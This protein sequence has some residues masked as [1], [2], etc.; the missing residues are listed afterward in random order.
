MFL[1]SALQS[2]QE[3]SIYLLGEYFSIGP[4]GRANLSAF[5]FVKGYVAESQFADLEAARMDWN[6]F[7]N[8][9]SPIL[10]KNDFAEKIST[11]RNFMRGG[12]N[13]RHLTRIIQWEIMLLAV[14]FGPFAVAIDNPESR[15]VARFE[16]RSKPYLDS[17]DSA[18][19]SNGETAQAYYKYEKFLDVEL[20]LVFN[21]LLI[22]LDEDTRRDLVTSQ[23]KWLTHRDAEFIF[24]DNNWVAAKFGSSFKISRVAY[25]S[26]L[27]KNRVTELLYYL[28]NY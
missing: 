2:I 4:S 25:R 16:E 21:A 26:D 23:N 11:Q 6:T 17:I 1:I 5:K 18:S 9:I 14:W 12:I 3:T 20:N 7:R 8:K 22:E 24:I 15:V 19:E 27:V 28:Q 10:R 13:L